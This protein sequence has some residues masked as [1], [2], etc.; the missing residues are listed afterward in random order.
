[1]GGKP[2]FAEAKVSWEVAPNP[3]F[4]VSGLRAMRST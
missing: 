4:Q 3:A 1:M 2:T